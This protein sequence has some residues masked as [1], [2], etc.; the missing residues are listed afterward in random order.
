MVLV[1]TATPVTTPVALTVATPVL[2]LLHEP[3]VVA[4]VNAAVP[5]R[6]MLTGLVGMIPDDAFTVTT[7]VVMQ[8]VGSI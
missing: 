5:P 3:P 8:P 2:V 7:V 1:P 4:S 6:Q